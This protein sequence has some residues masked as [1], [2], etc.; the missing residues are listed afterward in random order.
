M[1]QLIASEEPNGV[2]LASDINEVIWG[3]IAFFVIVGLIVWLAGPAIA[4]AFRGRTERI[5]AELNAAK[6]ARAEAE[7][8]LT[9]STADLPDVSAE[10]ERIRAEAT[11]AAARLKAD[12][13]ARAEAEAEDIRSRGTTEVENYRRQALADLTAELAQATKDS[14]E[15]IVVANLDQSS[16]GDL[17]DSYITQVEQGS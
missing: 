10:E 7:A 16:H 8:A 2:H 3:S 11:D 13:I 9:S 6:E 17:I 14:A 12:L 4:K 5:E 1:L 15:A